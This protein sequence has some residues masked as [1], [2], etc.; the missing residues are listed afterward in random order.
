MANLS[1]TVSSISKAIIGEATKIGG[2]LWSRIQN[3]SRF[4]VK[5]YSQALIDT[6]SA[7]A[8][9]DMTPDEGVNSGKAAAFFFCMMIAQ[10]TEATLTAVQ[11]FIDAVID[12]LKVSINAALPFPIL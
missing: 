12:T 9:G 7:V 1:A 6:A 3:A 10:A 11:K 8:M 4:Y 5:A 2:E